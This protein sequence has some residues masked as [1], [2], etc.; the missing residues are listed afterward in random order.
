[1]TPDSTKGFAIIV[2]AGS[3]RR[4]PGPR[5]KQFLELERRPLY[6]WSLATFQNSPQ[7]AGIILVGPGDGPQTLEDMRREC[8]GFSKLLAVVAGGASRT[9]SVSCGFSALAHLK[10]PPQTPILVHDGVRPLVTP[11]LIERV[12][13]RVEPYRAVIPCTTPTATVKQL[14]GDTITKTIDRD[15]LGLA[16]TPQGISY[17]LLGQALDWWRKHP[18][19]TIT[20]EGSLLENLA[21]AQRCR[22]IITKV[23]GDPDNLKIT[24]PGDLER[25]RMIYRRQSAAPPYRPRM[26]TGFGYDVHAFADGRKLILGG[27]EIVGHPGLAGHSDADVLVHAL[28]DALLG[29]VGAG[30]IGHHF[31]DL[32]P[33]FKNMCSLKFLTHALTLVRER[34]FYLEAAD[35]TVVAQRPR[36]APHIPSMRDNLR[37]CIGLPCQINIKATTTEGLGF[38]GRGEGI[39]AYAVAT[40]SELPPSTP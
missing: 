4:C 7:I 34:G 32:D 13:Q 33:A 20:D 5:S 37:A 9:A 31:P 8:T 22:V 17:Q 39:A 19:P 36:L 35:I 27:I 30:D 40:V 15:N 24:V 28:V 26:A 12:I 2:A 11:E 3:G 38:T 10:L 23:D 29:A 18:H 6:Q 1:M 21:P 16:Q 25:A 14:S